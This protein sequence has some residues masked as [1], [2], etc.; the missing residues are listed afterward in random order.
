MALLMQKE[1]LFRLKYERKR[2]DIGNKLD[3]VK[4]NLWW[5]LQR[6]D[7]R[8]ELKRYLAGLLE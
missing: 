3:F 5:G 8:D 1:P 6:E 2:H 7:M 4:A